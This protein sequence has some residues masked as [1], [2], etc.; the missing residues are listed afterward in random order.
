M[1]M[2]SEDRIVLAGEYVLGV[3]DAGQMAQ[4]EDD[5]R[6]DTE[7]RAAVAEWRQRFGELD[8]LAPGIAPGPDLW[9]RI[10]RAIALPVAASARRSGTLWRN[11][12]FWRGSAFAAAA[13]CM[14]FAIGLVLQMQRPQP[15]VVAILEAQDST[16][17]VIVEAYADGSIRLVPLTDIPV[18]EGRALQVW[19]LWDRAV[20]PVPLGVM[21][22]ARQAVFTAGGQPRP[23]P[24]QLYEISLE[25]AAGSPTG[26]PT[27]PIL[28]KGT[29]AAPR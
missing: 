26:R 29:A 22:R 21:D 6:T 8:E 28:F 23:Q 7:L 1:S 17:G 9:S 12:A 13:A 24:Q 19:T 25:P 16:P 10:E 5:L 14:V 27:G 11:L 15:V 2:P 4:V 18:P 20:G 3:L